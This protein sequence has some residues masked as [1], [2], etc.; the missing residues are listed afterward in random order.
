MPPALLGNLS[1]SGRSC[2]LPLP[3][4]LRRYLD[5][6]DVTPAGDARHAPPSADLGHVLGIGDLQSPDR[7]GDE[8]D[9]K[10]KGAIR[11]GI[12]IQDATCIC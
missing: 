12:W 2:I 9:Q 6:E 10:G 11:G 3:D 4:S 8:E 5:H 7:D 1:G